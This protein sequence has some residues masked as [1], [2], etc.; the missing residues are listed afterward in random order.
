[1]SVLAGCVSGVARTPRHMLGTENCTRTSHRDTT[2][3][4]FSDP[5][6]FV[7][8]DFRPLVSTLLTFLF[9]R[10]DYGGAFSLMRKHRINM[11]LL[12]DHAPARFLSN[13]TSFVTQVD[14]VNHVNLFLTDL[15]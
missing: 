6:T 10:L 1:M 5:F 8:H 15:Q 12:H 9:A 3:P 7:G 2:P 13:V 14:N 4:L 11:N